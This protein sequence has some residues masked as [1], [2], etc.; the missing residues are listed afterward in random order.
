MKNITIIQR[1]LDGGG[2]EKVLVNLLNN[3]DYKKYKVNLITIYKQGVHID[4]I[5]K[6]V[7]LK[8]IYNP[9]KFNQKILQSIYCRIIMYLYTK[10][11]RLLYK[12]II[13][14]NS[15]V[16]IAF[17]EGEAT[18]FLKYSCNKNSKKIAWVH[19][20]IDMH[21]KSTL[22]AFREYY[23]NI[24]HIICVSNDAKISFDNIYPEYKHKTQVI[25]NLIDNNEIYKKSNEEINYSFTGKTVIAVGRL[26]QE[27]R[28]DILIKAHKLL[29]DDNVRH[30]LLIL[31]VGPKEYE[32]KDLIQQLKVEDTVELLGFKIN[33]YPYIKNSDIF[34]MSSEYEGYS[35]VIAEAL[36][37]G[38]PIVSTKCMGPCEILEDGELGI[39][40]D[41]NDEYKLAIGI[42]E[43]LLNDELKTYYKEKSKEAINKFNNKEIM[44]QIYN[45]I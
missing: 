17:L 42:K 15:D 12:W 5:N 1:T 3:I 37:L 24:D 44:N 20:N 2:A 7:N 43:M 31:G 28:F 36:L 21:N 35:L 45:V 38:T 22:D 39:I 30:K 11:P 23:N 40:V 34:V 41:K 29:I 4:N 6:N 10:F 19:C 9:N 18:K 26:V 14:S 32:L 25:Y 13:G 33:P 27:K 8:C 16:E